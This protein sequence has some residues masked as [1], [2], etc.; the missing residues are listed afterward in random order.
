LYISENNKRKIEDV[1]S[2]ELIYEV[3]AGFS[4]D[5]VK[6]MN[7][8][9]NQIIEEVS[10]FDTFETDK[11][12]D[13]KIN[14][15]IKESNLDNVCKISKAGEKENVTATKTGTRTETAIETGKETK[16]ATKTGTIEKEDLSF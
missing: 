16:T 8:T 10:I 1:K 4:F 13:I 6:A 3:I 15:S 9:E 2:N 5:N 11:P 12:T 7:N 14:I